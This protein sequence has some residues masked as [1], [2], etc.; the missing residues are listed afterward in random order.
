MRNLYIDFDGVILD[1]IPILY[2]MIEEAGIDKYEEAEVRK[3]YQNV[4]WAELL[5][6][7][8]QINDSITCIQKLINSNKFNITILTHVNSLE[9]ACEKV[10]FIRNYFFDITIIPVPKAISKTEM[11]H[12]QDAILV[13]DYSGNLR[14]WENAGGI[15]VRFNTELE[16]KGFKVI[17]RLDELL[18]M[19]F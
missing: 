8:D 14:E 16:S 11:V 9:E 19:D 15:G 18:T 1:T 4:N 6:T 13:D 5:E 3:F 7:T 12:T 2:Q 10:K 17:S